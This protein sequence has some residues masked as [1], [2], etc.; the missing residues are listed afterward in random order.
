MSNSVSN[1]GLTKPPA[2]E[3]VGKP[4]PAEKEKEKKE[5]TFESFGRIEDSPFDQA[6]VGKSAAGALIDAGIPAAEVS[7][8]L[9]HPEHGERIA[10][11]LARGHKVVC[12]ETKTHKCPDKQ[13]LSEAL[14]SVHNDD[15]K[16]LSAM[17]NSRLQSSRASQEI[18]RVL[19]A[20]GGSFPNVV[21]ASLINIMG[22]LQTPEA[23]ALAGSCLQLEVA[24]AQYDAKV[25]AKNG[26]KD[27]ATALSGILSGGI[28]QS[29]CNGECHLSDHHIE[30]LTAFNTTT[31][32][33]TTTSFHFE[34]ADGNIV[35]DGLG[36]LSFEHTSCE[37]TT[38][39]EASDEI[40][41]QIGN[42][43]EGEA[44][45]TLTDAQRLSG[46]HKEKEAKEQDKQNDLIA[47]ADKIRLAST[48]EL[49]NKLTIEKSTIASA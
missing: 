43:V 2:I 42:P 9:E 18:E 8:V 30:N 48:Q 41:E 10:K 5:P 6:R 35:D 12:S 40:I 1:S 27:A 29:A 32:E 17:L 23:K 37:E 38:E 34:D 13:K 24:H 46:T 7:T 15:S 25:Q 3:L 33:V 31:T 11:A 45:K 47:A 49:K 20:M 4:K 19:M 39:Y 36:E 28:P 44:D 16:M 21:V 26:N 14:G 22:S